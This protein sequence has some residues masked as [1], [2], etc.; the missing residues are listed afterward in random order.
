MQ[1]RTLLR[2]SIALLSCG[3]L[4]PAATAQSA[5]LIADINPGKSVFSSRPEK[6]FEVGSRIVFRAQGGNYGTEWWSVDKSS[7]PPTL[8]RDIQPGS[9]SSQLYSN[10]EPF[11][12]RIWFTTEAPGTGREL[13]VSDGPPNGTGLFTDLSLGSS[14]SSPEELTASGS[15]LWF[16]A[17]EAFQ[18]RRYL[19]RSDGT[20]AGTKIVFEWTSGVFIRG[21]AAIGNGKVA[22]SYQPFGRS[23]EFWVSDGTRAG[24]GPVLDSARKPIVLDGLFDHQIFGDKVLLSGSFGD[25]SGILISDG[26]TAGTKLL[27]EGVTGPVDVEALAGRVYFVSRVRNDLSLWVTDGTSAGTKAILRDG[28]C[29]NL[30]AA[31]ARLWFTARQSGTGR[32]PWITDGTIAGT[33]MVK[34][35]APGSESSNAR[36]FLAIGSGAVFSAE[37]RTTGSELWISDGSS[38]GTRVLDLRPGSQSSFP[39]AFLADRGRFFLTYD[40]AKV[41]KEVFISDGTIAGTRVFA[42][43]GVDAGMSS[44]PNFVTVGNGRIWFSADDGQNGQEL[45]VSDGSSAG[46]KMVVDLWP[47][48]GR[49]SSPN[50]ILPIGQN[51]L[52]VANT[53]DRK[54]KVYATD[55]SAAGTTAVFEGRLF[56]G[57]TVR[58]QGKTW[59]RASSPSTGEELY[60]SDG[61]AKNTKVALDIIPGATSSSSRGLTLWRNRLYFVAN[62]F[63]EGR[64]LFVSDGTPAG[65]KLVTTLKQTTNV[66][67]FAIY[68]G[69]I[70]ISARD[71][72]ND[73]ELWTSDGTPAATKLFANLHPSSSSE[74]R[75]LTPTDGLMYF[76]ARHPSVGQVVFATDGTLAGTRYLRNPLALGGRDLIALGDRAI[77]RAANRNIVSTDGSDFGTYPVSSFA[78]PTAFRSFGRRSIFFQAT[79]AQR[80][81]ELW[82]ATGARF[83]SRNVIDLE[84]GA[85]GSFAR[86]A[87]L[88]DGQLLV[89]GVTT[90]AGNELWALDIPTTGASA[91]VFGS[92]CSPSRASAPRISSDDPILNTTATLQGRWARPMALGATFVGPELRPAPMPFGCGVYCQL[93]A[94]LLTGAFVTDAKG[95]WTTKLVIPNDA[96]LIGLGAV[97]QSFFPRFIGTLPEVEMSDALRIFFGR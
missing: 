73:V 37:T 50:N 16:I 13:W 40:D 77:F 34:D 32:E 29:H 97:L 62:D 10:V 86:P 6:F 70:W 21:L 41:G 95:A 38:A 82:R 25:K 26:T 27:V 14:S 1:T 47:G 58:W 63:L 65:T 33:R 89:V 72:V 74:P 54:N 81:H 87:A 15:Y 94:A 56:S 61:S 7:G 53:P 11:R 92:P 39:L 35:L 59:F 80:G 43:V 83:S 18:N 31:G 22:F 55:G 28:D 57:N 46:T 48:Q 71:R 52:F 49:G 2:A 30:R 64:Q 85:Q 84:V 67:S 93:D 20:V 36:N 90:A 8:L 4:T 68:K 60:S 42:N 23:I 79:D 24:T 88:F 44:N 12:G 19:Y 66:E 91:E 78:T 51:A 9:Q 17:R 45:W 96:S 69:R 75:E 3:A 5:R 76:A